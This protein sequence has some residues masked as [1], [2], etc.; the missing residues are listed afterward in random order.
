MLELNNRIQ[1]WSHETLIL[2]ETPIGVSLTFLPPNSPAMLLVRA[3]QFVFL[4]FLH[5][6]YQSHPFC[7]RMILANE[8]QLQL[9]RTTRHRYK[10]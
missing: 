4:L 10:R 9:S 3:V 6:S 8:T 1:I 5:A 7:L 2:G